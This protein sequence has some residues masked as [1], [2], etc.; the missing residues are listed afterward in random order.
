MAE[1][2][3]VERTECCPKTDEKPNKCILL[4]DFA[5]DS[6]V[7]IKIA[8]K[9]QVSNLD[10]NPD[11]GFSIAWF[12]HLTFSLVSI[13]HS[14]PLL[15]TSVSR[16]STPQLPLF[17]L[18]YHHQSS[19]VSSVSHGGQF[20]HF[21]SFK[22]LSSNW[23]ILSFSTCNL[24]HYHLFCSIEIVLHSFNRALP[25]FNSIPITTSSPSQHEDQRKKKLRLFPWMPSFPSSSFYLLKKWFR[26]DVYVKNG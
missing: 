20:F 12:L 14:Q 22:H 9:G 2:N 4:L 16:D 24:P 6:E 15:K 1:V 5:I 11:S 21:I 3:S 17:S 8:I 13:F 19:K 25:L 18:I 26:L 23:V 7:E 10:H